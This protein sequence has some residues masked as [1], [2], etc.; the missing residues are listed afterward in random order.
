LNSALAPRIKKLLFVPVCKKMCY[1][2]VRP[3]L[4][5]PTAKEI[6]HLHFRNMLLFESWDQ[7]VL[8]AYEGDLHGAREDRH[9]EGYRGP[10]PG[11]AG[12]Q[13]SWP[14]QGATVY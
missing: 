11:D 5:N 10:P 12:V 9:G 4:V 13:K 1:T 8:E 14:S 3:F 6:V 2:G 7:S